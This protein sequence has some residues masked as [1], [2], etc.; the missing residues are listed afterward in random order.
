MNSVEFGE[1]SARNGGGNPEPSFFVRP[2]LACPN[3]R[4]KEE[5]VETLRLRPTADIHGQEKVQTT[6]REGSESYR[7][8]KIRWGA[9]PVR[10]RVP[11]PAFVPSSFP[12]LRKVEADGRLERLAQS[13]AALPV[14]SELDYSF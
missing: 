5:G 14:T 3:P 1:T 12:D 9:S 6:N 8:T 4:G 2:P 10:V 7:S 13:V 11:P